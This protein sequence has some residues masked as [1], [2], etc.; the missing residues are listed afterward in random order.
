MKYRSLI[1][2]HTALLLCFI[3]G[4]VAEAC[5]GDSSKFTGSWAV[6]WC[7][8]D[9]PGP[10][11]GFKVFLIQEGDRVCGTHYGEDLRA[12]RID[13]G[14]PSSIVGSAIGSTAILVVT[15]GRNNGVYLVKATRKG[16]SIDWRM[17]ETIADG[18]NGQP[19]FISTGEVLS[20]AKTEDRKI[21]DA[22]KKRLSKPYWQP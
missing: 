2:L 4:F 19:A 8:K 9:R 11:G 14:S 17:I 22:C 10:C 5:A 16:T 6:K 20:A 13:E 7:V 15:S 12:N 3:A 18:N 1:P 21:M